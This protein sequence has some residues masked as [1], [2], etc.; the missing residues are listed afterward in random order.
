MPEGTLFLLGDN[1][2][3]SKDS[4]HSDIGVVDERNILGE[5]V[6]RVLP[7]SDFGRI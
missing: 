3:R 1:R 5:V 6:F 2:P 4:R 7:F